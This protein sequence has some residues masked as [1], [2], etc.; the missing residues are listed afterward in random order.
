MGK[1]VW[2]VRFYDHIIRNEA[3]LHRIRTYIANNP[4]QWAIDEENPDNARQ[5]GRTAVRP[6]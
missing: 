3:D 1:P 4:M 2:Q 6:Y 5:G